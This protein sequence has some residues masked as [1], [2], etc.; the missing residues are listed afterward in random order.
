MKCKQDVG[1]NLKVSIITPCFNSEK[2]IRDT[3]ESVLNQTYKNIEYIIVDGL[4]TDRTLDVIKEYEPLFRGRMRYISESDHGIYNAMNKG[5]RMSSG[6]LIGI[7]NS[8]DYYETDAVETAINNMSSA[9]C[10]VIYGYMGVLKGNTLRFITK[11]NHINL[12]DKMIPHPTCFVTRR[13]YQKYGLFLEW[14]K[15]AADYELMLRLHTKD[16][17]VF[18]QVKKAQAYFRLGGASANDKYDLEREIA[19]VMHGG[20]SV[21]G[22]LDKTLNFAVNKFILR[23]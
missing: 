3:I 9:Q 5:I 13:T 21:R 10:Q 2:T 22:L 17:V 23:M 6:Q 8:D 19:R 11:D 18:T 4:S 14:F 15:V 16:D 7:I 12:N 20:L 1:M